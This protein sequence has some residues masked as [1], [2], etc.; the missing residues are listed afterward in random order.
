MVANS[1]E[2]EEIETEQ[3]SQEFDIDME[4]CVISVQT[5]AEP[6]TTLTAKSEPPSDPGTTMKSESAQPTLATVK[7]EQPET[8][9]RFASTS[10][11]DISKISKKRLAAN[12]V[13]STSWGVN[14]LKGKHLQC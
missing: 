7:S 11:E 13:N 14:I 9:P 2:I 5:P 8:K 6:E 12:T 3:L 10:N 1:L 4:E